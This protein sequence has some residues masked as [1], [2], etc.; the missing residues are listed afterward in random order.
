MKIARIELFPVEYPFRGEFRIARGSVGSPT[1][2]RQSVAAKLTTEDGAVGWGESAPIRQW[3]YETLESVYTTLSRY[4][5]PAVL[6]ADIFDIDGLHRR[7]D[8]EIAPGH[9]VGQPIARAAIDIAAHDALCKTLGVSLHRYWG[10]SRL[11]S[12]PLSWTVAVPTLEKAEEAVAEGRERGYTNFNIK[13][14]SEDR[15]EFDIALARFARKAAPDGFLWADA[16][17]GYSVQT[18]KKAARLMADAGVD[19]LEQPLPSN[20]V[21]GY[22]ELRRLNALPI[23]VDE[24]V[25]APRDLIEWI[26]LDLIDGVAMKP[27]RVGGLGPQRRLIETAQDAGLMFLGSGLT[28]PDV[29]FA[30]S[31]QIYAAY[32]LRFPAALNGP[33]FLAESAASKGVE[34]K[35]GCAL[36]PDG[37]GLGIEMDETALERLRVDPT[38][39]NE[40]RAQDR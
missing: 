15:L 5:A 14:G 38:P 4:F 18:A 25:I 9:T 11:R 40:R 33:Q 10:V 20:A 26:R 6:G 22:R 37:P 30:A 16:N 27:L 2:G 12:L 29:A 21:A 23:A 8:A 1:M 3:S 34:V 19:V 31:V 36:V 32:G 13:A 17:G 28:D 39:S 24:G 35:N 7:M